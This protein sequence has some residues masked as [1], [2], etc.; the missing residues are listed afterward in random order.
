MLT[1]ITTFFIACFVLLALTLLVFSVNYWV[2]GV[3]AGA[4]LW[5]AWDA[6]LGMRMSA[7]LQAAQLDS[8]SLK[9]WKMPI[10][11]GQW[12]DAFERM[13]RLLRDKDRALVIEKTRHEAFLQAIQ[14]SPNGVV[15]LDKEWRIS[16]C[17]QTAAQHL[18]LDAQRDIA[19]HIGNLVRDPAFTAYLLA[20]KPGEEMVVSGAQNSLQRPV[21][22]SVQLHAY[23]ALS[24]ASEFNNTSSSGGALLLSRDVT[25]LEQTDTMR[26]D[27]VANVS[28]EIRTPLTVLSGFVETLQTLP[29]DA[30]Q[31]SRYLGLMAQQSQRMQDLV[32]DLLTLSKLEG[33]PMPSIDSGVAVHALLG[34]VEADAR[35]LLQLHDTPQRL[36]F[37]E[38]YEAD[39][40]Y[41]I[42]GVESELLSA[43]QNLVSNALRYTPPLGVVQV[44][45]RVL[46]DGRGQFTVTDT[47][48]GI[49]PEHI[50][51]LT[52][53]FYRV[54][55]SRS[56]ESG[57]TGLGL[58]I[59][60]HVVQR[61]GG[62]LHIESTVGQGSSFWFTLPA[63]RVA[64]V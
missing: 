5:L 60:K 9:Q 46:P 64:L 3:F 25:A 7:F 26:R 33:S 31:R 62:E 54:D 43:M 48:P 49:A 39:G 55:R 47:G 32:S 18:G 35:A 59:V 58:S 53:R 61:H 57:G 14:N 21:R 45:W 30:G 29:L 8:D 17:N 20:A 1:R 50:A 4:L 36:R 11:S 38:V 56:R 40:I 41:Q 27:F 42:L 52:E 6:W 19:Q 10:F 37:E 44:R 23:A 13:Q 34:R 22:I 28:H 15:L 16:W 12:G 2:W 63:A 51:R 24:Y